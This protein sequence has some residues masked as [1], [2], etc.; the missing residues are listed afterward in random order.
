MFSS[1]YSKHIGVPESDDS[2][3]DNSE[4]DDSKNDTVPEACLQ[5]EFK[6]SPDYSW[7]NPSL[8]WTKFKYA[9]NQEF[10]Y[11]YK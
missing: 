2:E 6:F 11:E 1:E 3:S 7:L 5:F 4:S 9:G 8:G 10:I